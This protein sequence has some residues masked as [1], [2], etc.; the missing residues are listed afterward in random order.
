MSEKPTW[1][2]IARKFGL[3]A[4]RSGKFAVAESKLLSTKA[5]E[6]WKKLDAEYSVREKAGELGKKAGEAAAKVKKEAETLYGK[7][8]QRIKQSDSIDAPR[9]LV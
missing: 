4:K 1:R 7:S 6:K 8:R 2:E 3:V 5:K 9:E